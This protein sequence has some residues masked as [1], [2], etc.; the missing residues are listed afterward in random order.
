MKKID[1]DT[2]IINNITLPCL[3]GVFDNERTEKQLLTITLKLSVDTRIAGK[4]DKVHDTVSYH[5]IAVAVESLVSSS[6][7]FLLE[8]L[9]QEIA[10]LCLA[11]KRVHQVTVY[12]EK[13]KAVKLAKSAAI[14]ITR[15]RLTKIL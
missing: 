5:D 15:K 6:Q 8:K 2:I 10:D 13:P 7:F 9:A 3:I 1:L 14:E 11:D 12:I 4:T